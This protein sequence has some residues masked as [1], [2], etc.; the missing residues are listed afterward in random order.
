MSRVSR[1]V[2]VQ[3]FPPVVVQASSPVVVQASSLLPGPVSRLFPLAASG[4]LLSA[5]LLAAE[6]V[7][8]SASFNLGPGEVAPALTLPRFNPTEHPDTPVLQRV[9][10]SLEVEFTSDIALG[11]L[12][13]RPGPVAWSLGPATV[14]VWPVDATLGAPALLSLTLAGADALPA[15]GRRVLDPAPRQVGRATLL[16]AETGVAAFAGSGA[17]TYE[18][19]FEAGYSWLATEPELAGGFYANDR[20]HGRLWVSYAAGPELGSSDPPVL[21][22]HRLGSGASVHL[23]VAGRAG[24]SVVIEAAGQILGPWTP[25][26]EVRLDAGGLGGFVL[27]PDAAFPVRFHRV[28]WREATPGD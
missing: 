7:Y 26:A 18:V 17:M 8:E 4:L 19:G 1:P 21:T 3:A 25:V 10:V 15:T 11:W 12:A 14:S 9:R 22:A 5:R 2:V 28:R 27:E 20:V 6:F 16:E 13:L 23:A 24:A